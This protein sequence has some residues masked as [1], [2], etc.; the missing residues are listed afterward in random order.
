M[1]NHDDGRHGGPSRK[2]NAADNTEIRRWPAVA[3]VQK[4]LKPVGPRYIH[5]MFRYVWSEVAFMEEFRPKSQ[6]S[7]VEKQDV[8]TQECRKKAAGF[9]DW[10]IKIKN[11]LKIFGRRRQFVHERAGEQHNNECLQATVKHGGGSLKVWGCISANGVGDLVTINSG[12]KRQI[13]IHNAKPSGRGMIYFK[14]LLQQDDDHKVIKNCLQHRDEQ[15]L[16]W[17]HRAPTLASW[18]MFEITQETEESLSTKMFGTA[19]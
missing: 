12:K 14:F 16:S 11:I 5:L 7:N 1:D 18:N 13:L 15:V 19:Y 9:P 10:W 17:P 2:L 8:E 4:W 3:L 6:T